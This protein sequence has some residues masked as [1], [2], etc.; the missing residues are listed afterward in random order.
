MSLSAGNSW[1][2]GTQTPDAV[3]LSV[4]LLP[5]TLPVKI[6]CV[7]HTELHFTNGCLMGNFLIWVCDTSRERICVQGTSQ[8]DTFCQ[9]IFTSHLGTEHYSRPVVKS[10]CRILLF[11]NVHGHSRVKR[12][13]DVL[14]LQCYLEDSL[15]WNGLRNLNMSPVLARQGHGEKRESAFQ[16]SGQHITVTITSIKYGSLSFQGLLPEG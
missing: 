12:R 6:S 3:F 8:S 2:V 5:G 13:Y 14:W 11:L 4:V 7:P 9:Q 16:L 15:R 10:D 1:N